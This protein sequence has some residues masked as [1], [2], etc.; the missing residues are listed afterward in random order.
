MSFSRDANQDDKQVLPVSK[1]LC[2]TLNAMQIDDPEGKA[3]SVKHASR[4]WVQREEFLSSLGF[5]KAFKFD[6]GQ[7]RIDLHKRWLML[8]VERS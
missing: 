4:V 3:L 2:T 5:C 8:P 6:K 7:S 1:E